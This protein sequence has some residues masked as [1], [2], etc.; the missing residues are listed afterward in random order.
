MEKAQKVWPHDVE[1]AWRIH[2]LLGNL[3]DLVL[4]EEVIPSATYEELAVLLRDTLSRDETAI[5]GIW[6]Q[7]VTPHDEHQWSEVIA[8]I[9][10][11][12]RS[13]QPLLERLA[14]ARV[15]AQVRWSTSTCPTR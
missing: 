4:E 11:R 13:S 15:R 7:R 5:P 8:I 10:A 1:A 6:D 9:G 3:L 12:V 2:L 14:T